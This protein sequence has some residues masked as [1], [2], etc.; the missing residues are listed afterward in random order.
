MFGNFLYFI[1]V[2]L[3]YSTYQPPER[4]NFPPGDT[5]LF[6]LSF[7]LFFY[8]FV[9]YRFNSLVRNLPDQTFIRS[10]HRFNRLIHQMTVLAVML[11]AVD[12]Y[13]LNISYYFPPVPI[14]GQSPT[15]E[16]VFFLAFFILHLMVVYGQAHDA[17]RLI[18][19]SQISRREYIRSNITISLPVLLPWLL[20]SLT[21][22]LIQVLPFEGPRRWLDTTGGQAVYFLLFLV[23][24]SIIGPYLIQKFWKCTPLPAGYDRDRIASVCRR[25][26]LEYAEILY[27]PI[28]GGRMITA[29]VMG[30]VKRFRYILVT[31]SLLQLLAPE[32]IDAVIA[33]E[34][35]HIKKKHLLFY[36]LF[37]VGYLIL[38][39]TAFD[40]IIYGLI[41]FTPAS[42]L[43]T[44]TGI[45]HSTLVSTV[46]SVCIIT[47]FIIYFRFIFGFFMRNFERQADLY[48]Y[49]LF[50]SAAPLISTLKKIAVTSGQPP[51]KP[52]WHHFSIRQRID[53]LE[54]AESD[55]R[56]VRR[57]DSKV[58]KYLAVY[59]L[60]VAAVATAGYQLNF[61]DTGRRLNNHVLIRIL[62]KEIEKTPASSSLHSI[63]GDL[64]LENKEYG[65]AIGA[66]ERAVRL[67]DQDPRPL[68]N[69]AWLLATAEDPALR[70]PDLAVYQAE[71][72]ARLQQVPYVLDTL[73]ECYYVSGRYAE[74]VAAE[75]EALRMN[76][77]NRAYYEKQLEKFR[78]AAGGETGGKAR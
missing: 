72:A 54:K 60:A 53:Y 51:E 2:L 9:K 19:R 58:K 49:T 24:V 12:I 44:G 5:I 11:L 21:S 78:A 75:T 73:A 7:F 66:Y 43:L 34:I 4:P 38:S 18:Y 69:Y 10:D 41:Y 59:C 48:V 67:D 6:F 42:D 8:G 45:S 17:H 36:I 40:L 57:H 15:F 64:Y 30:L 20:L 71:K 3:I 62:E 22:D 55:R 46:F 25:A 61:G 39:Y 32:E 65:A 33:H 37:L 16:A 77:K 31:R 50:D 52:N 63:L 76:P 35:G 23:L 28:F 13:G 68:N 26:K 29:G 74:A 70:N 47:L 56:W 14:L 1:I 27:W